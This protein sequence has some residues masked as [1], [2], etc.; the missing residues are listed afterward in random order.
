MPTLPLDAILNHCAPVDEA[1]V[2]RLSI[3]PACPVIERAEDGVEE[4][5]PMFPLAKIVNIDTPVDEATLNGLRLEVEVACTLNA[6][7]D[8]VALTPAND[9][10]SKN[11]ADPSVVADDQRASLPVVPPESD[12]LTPSDDVATQRVEVPVDISTIAEVPVALVESRNI[13]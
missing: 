11:E 1:T 7:D 12:P 8:D 3:S 9:P 4:P 2:K 6:N 13:P 5:I 10:L